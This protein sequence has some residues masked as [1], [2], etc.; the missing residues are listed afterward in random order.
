MNGEQN[1]FFVSVVIPSVD[2]R[3]VLIDLLRQ[4]QSQTYA[5]MEIIVVD[6]TES[7]TE[8]FRSEIASL[9]NVR[10]IHLRERG[11]PNARN[12]GIRNARGE[13]ILFLDDDIIPDPDLVRAHAEC[14]GDPAVAGVGGRILG[15]YDERREGVV[16]RFNPWTCKV[17]RNFGS[18]EKGMADHLPGGNM[19]LR[20]E[21]FDKVGGFDRAYGGAASIGEETDFSLRSRKA[22]FRFIFEPRAVMTH[23]RLPRGGCRHDDFGDWL[24][25]QAHNTTLFAL[26]HMN[27]I[28]LPAYLL[29]RLVRQALFVFEHGRFDLL[30]KGMLGTLRGLSTNA[31]RVALT[32]F[33]P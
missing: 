16:G 12:V 30:C 31:R 11:L 13:I 17:T 6:Q 5:D 10:Y 32:A 28:A 27:P 20:R 21:V 1:A 14:Y 8:R 33:E 4:M 25:W 22:G 2:R 15:G 24:F 9:G 7:G 26:R 19:S 29:T 18:T 23:L 3:D